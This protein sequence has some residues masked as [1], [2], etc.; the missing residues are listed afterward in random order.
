MPVPPA[1]SIPIRKKHPVGVWFERVRSSLSGC[2]HS[3]DL[4]GLSTHLAG[5]HSWPPAAG[6]GSRLLILILIFIQ[7]SVVNWP[8]DTSF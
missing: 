7:L 2:P 1:Q 5:E 3:G 8:L 4:P 6:S